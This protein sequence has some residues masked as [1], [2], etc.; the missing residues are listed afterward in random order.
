MEKAVIFTDG[1]FVENILRLMSI[2]VE[3]V[4]RLGEDARRSRVVNNFQELPC[5]T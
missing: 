5:S 4:R 2:H 1:L 3:V